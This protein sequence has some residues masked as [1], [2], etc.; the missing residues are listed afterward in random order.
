MYGPV[1]S[2]YVQY[3]C[4]SFIRLF[5]HT[6]L[7]N[8]IRPGSAQGRWVLEDWKGWEVERDAVCHC[9]AFHLISTQSPPQPPSLSG[10]MLMCRAK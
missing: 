10:V 8:L 3:V 2:P 1:P 4:E 6:A 5:I 9:A 7:S